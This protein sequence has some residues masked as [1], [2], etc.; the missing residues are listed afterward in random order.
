MSTP[1]TARVAKAVL[2][3]LVFV[4]CVAALAAAAYFVGLGS[5]RPSE[6]GSPAIPAPGATDAGGAGAGRK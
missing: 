1:P 4:A 2:R 3:R 6:G 5:R